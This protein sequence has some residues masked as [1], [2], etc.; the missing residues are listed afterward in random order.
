MDY[1]TFL[2]ALTGADRSYSDR[3]LPTTKSLIREVSTPSNISSELPEEVMDITKNDLIQ[4]ALKLQLGGKQP[5]I[6]A[7]LNKQFL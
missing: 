4:L 2:N 7:A 1:T 3:A 6:Y 5:P